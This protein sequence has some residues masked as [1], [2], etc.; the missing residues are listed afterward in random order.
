MTID[1][2]PTRSVFLP[3]LARGLA[4]GALGTV[5]LW[6]ALQAQAQP[7]MAPGAAA[8]W[9]ACARVDDPKGRLACYD[10]WAGQQPTGLETAPPAD[11]PGSVQVPPGVIVTAG[12]GP[13]VTVAKTDEPVVPKCHNDS[14][15]ELSR[16]WELETD[17]DCGRFGVR[18]Y[19]PIGLSAVQGSS[20][21]RTPTSPAP[22]HDATTPVD[23]RNSEARLQLSVRTKFAQ[24]LL[25]PK[26]G[27]RVD[28][29]WFA[30]SQQSY[31]QL[32]SPGLSRPFRST[33]HEPEVMYVYPSDFNLPGGWR[34]RYTGLGLVHQS[35]GQTLPFSRSWNRV[36]LMAGM[37]N[38]KQFRITGR[39]WHRLHED[40]DTD[41]N[42]DITKYIGRGEVT[43]SWNVNTDNTL[44]MTL[45][46]ALK[47]DG[48]GSARVEWMRALGP[49]QNG[50]LRG[51]LRLHT[52]LFT[53]YG[54]SLID[55][56]HK[57]TVLSVGLSL[58]DF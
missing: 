38:G 46:H 23:Y 49:K 3:R 52:A 58:V 14:Y 35:N 48:H 27:P 13:G 37:E 41:D 26:D 16:F 36:Y 9:R 1:Q 39:V 53:G 10:R 42:P 8:A 28:S 24:G 47:S 57:R 17:T 50:W 5:A 18:G 22:G 25:T 31:W 51:G 21:N 56:N 55:Y 30:Y 44:S 43:G 32:F 33:D 54:D 2:P 12:P 6:P 4:T 40:A 11:R 29:L 20:V 45:R 19:R 7:Q 34:M 15:S